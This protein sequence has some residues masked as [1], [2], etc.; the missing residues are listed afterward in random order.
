MPACGALTPMLEC[1]YVI[2]NGIQL[3][4]SIKNDVVT[5]DQV[6]SLQLCAKQHMQV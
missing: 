2:V 4:K 6:D 5:E 3:R 1:L